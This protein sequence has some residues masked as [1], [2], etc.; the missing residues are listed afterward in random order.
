MAVEGADILVI[1]ADIR[2]E[3]CGDRVFAFLVLG[4]VHDP[5]EQGQE[6]LLIQ[7]L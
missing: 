1:E 3:L 5:F 4:F 6:F 2:R 7:A